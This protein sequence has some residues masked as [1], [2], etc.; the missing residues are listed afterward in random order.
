MKTNA[1][2]KYSTTSI[3]NMLTFTAQKNRFT[4]DSV[5][6]LTED[7]SNYALG[8]HGTNYYGHEVSLYALRDDTGDVDAFLFH[9]RG[10]SSQ[11]ND[12]MYIFSAVDDPVS[13]LTGVGPLYGH[14]YVTP[15][16]IQRV[17]NFWDAMPGVANGSHSTCV[18]YATD[19]F[20]Y[21]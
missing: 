1:P 9:N 11:I 17:A 5:T 4:V 19:S 13:F 15:D 18:T 10:Q 14:V 21:A 12:D 3:L 6:G 8:V 20:A 2:Q 7:P 16:N